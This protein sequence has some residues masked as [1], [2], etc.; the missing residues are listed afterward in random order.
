MPQDHAPLHLHG[1]GE[2]SSLQRDVPIQ[3]DPLPNGLSVAHRELLIVL[4]HSRSQIGVPGFV[5]RG[6][7]ARGGLAAQLFGL[8]DH[9]RREHRGGLAGGGVGFGLQTENTGEIVLAV[10]DHD[11]VADLRKQLLELVLDGDGSDVLASTGH[12]QFLDSAGQINE[13]VLI[14]ATLIAGMDPPVFIQRLLRLLR[15]LQIP[16]HH[17]ASA[18]QQ[19]VHRSDPNRH[20]R[21]R[22]SAR[23]QLPRLLHVRVGS[24]RRAALALTQQVIDRNVELREEPERLDVHRR[25]TDHQA[26]TLTEPQLRPDFLEDELVGE[27]VPEGIVMLLSVLTRHAAGVAHTHRPVRYLPLQALHV[28]LGPRLHRVFVESA[29]DFGLHLLVQ[30]RHG[31]ADSG[32]R[33]LKSVDERALQRVGVADIHADVVV[34]GNHRVDVL[35]RDVVERKE[36]RLPREAARTLHSDRDG[37]VRSEFECLRT[38]TCTNHD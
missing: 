5:L 7:S 17:V 24:E 32:L 26:T 22:L 2:L 13:P 25:G 36:G 31:D 23:A 16:H 38:E 21:H 37:P 6:L 28:R 34:D 19:L 11:G 29:L 14:Y 3:H 18:V 15:H 10:A 1:G 27:P 4:L 12:D 8:L 20:A 9:V 30:T 33:D 35:R